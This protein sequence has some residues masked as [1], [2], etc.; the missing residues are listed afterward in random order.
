MCHKP[1]PEGRNARACR[2]LSPGTLT[3]KVL[4]KHTLAQFLPP[5]PIITENWLPPPKHHS[6]LPYSPCLSGPEPWK[7]LQLGSLPLVLPP[8]PPDPQ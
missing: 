1:A 5:Y 6:N 4:G 7:Q 2:S 8:S 3:L